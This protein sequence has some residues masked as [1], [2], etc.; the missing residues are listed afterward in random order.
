MAYRK[1]MVEPAIAQ[2]VPLLRS[3]SP[4]RRRALL[5]GAQLEWYHKGDVL[6]RQGEAARWVWFVMEGWVHLTRMPERTPEGAEGVVIFTITPEEVLCGISAL[7]E[8]GVYQVSGIAGTDCTALRITGQEL[9]KAVRQEAEFAYQTLRL[10]ARRQQHIAQQYGA[11]AE[12]VSRRLIRAI[13]RLEHQFGS[14][15]P[16]THRELAQMAWTTTESAIRTIRHFKQR[17]LLSG[18]RGLLRIDR[19][20]ALQQMLREANG[21]QEVRP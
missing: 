18:G 10:Y 2:Q 9:A 16:V 6:F 1:V 4:R 17:G 14:T 12:P 11:M 21:H 5:A 19:P 7:L 3:L 8:G 20:G 13:L 15:L